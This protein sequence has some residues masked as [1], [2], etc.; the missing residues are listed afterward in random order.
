MPPVFY[1]VPLLSWA[2]ENFTQNH[3]ILLKP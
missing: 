1:F 3:E 2:C